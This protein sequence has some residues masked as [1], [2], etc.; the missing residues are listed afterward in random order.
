M[1]KDKMLDIL[2]VMREGLKGVPYYDPNA[3]PYN[4]TILPDRLWKTLA[5]V[6]MIR[7]PAKQVGSYYKASRVMGEPVDAPELETTTSYKF[8]RLHFDYFRRLYQEEHPEYG[9]RLQW[10]IVID[11]DDVINDTEGVARRFC[12]IIQVDPAGVIY[13]WEQSSTINP[14]EAA[15]KETIN[16]SNCVIKEVRTFPLHEPTNSSY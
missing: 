5:P 15:F 2:E 13:K 10:P 1:M 6:F 4:P 11:G 3:R 14:L 7:H 12:E 8:T 16:G 9:D